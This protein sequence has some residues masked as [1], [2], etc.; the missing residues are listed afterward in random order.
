VKTKFSLTMLLLSLFIL[1]T[2]AYAVERLPANLINLASQPGLVLLKKDLN[3]NSLKLLSHF[4]TQK[5]VTYCGV[6]SAVMVLNSTD[7]VPPIDSQHPPYRYFNQ[8]NFFNDQVRK[9]ITPEEVKKNGIS[10]TKLSKVIQR[11][12]LK[13]KPYFA[14]ELNLEKF[15]K[16]LKN[17]ISNQQ[18]I[19]VNFLRT[20]LQQQGGGHH[21]PIAA[22]DKKTDRFLLLDVA[23]YKYSAYWAKTED[24][25][26][27]INTMDDGTYRGFII[28]N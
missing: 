19:I 23:Q 24:L 3:E 16:T 2:L 13:A 21:S 10:L 26:K 25:W 5:T 11:Y 7:I 15:R 8:D 4:T 17:A 12:G 27:A 28:I 1:T 14:N 18:F 9:I 6:A 22:Y 20:E